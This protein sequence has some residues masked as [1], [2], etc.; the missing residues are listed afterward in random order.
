MDVAVLSRGLRVNSVVTP[1]PLVT[2]GEEEEADDT[3][4][5]KCAVLNSL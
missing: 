3:E 4:D 1:S 5:L 2:P